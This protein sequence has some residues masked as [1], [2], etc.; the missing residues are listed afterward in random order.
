[1]KKRPRSASAT[2]EAILSSAR[3][4]FVRKGYAAGVREIAAGA[5][6]TAMMVNRYFG[7]KENLFVEV[8]N[9]VME[10][11]FVMTPE[12]VGASNPAAAFAAALTD[13]TRPDETPLDGFLIMFRSSTSEVAARLGR[14]QIEWGYQKTLRRALTGPDAAERAALALA[15]VSGFQVLRQMLKLPTLAKAKPA[16]LHRLLEVMFRAVLEEPKDHL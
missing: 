2:R 11:P 16:V 4:A 5:G 6:V 12:H 7:S 13:I 14:E 9:K 10:K 15:L 8:V 1:M 3:R